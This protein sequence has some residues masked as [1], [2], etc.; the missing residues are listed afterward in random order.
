MYTNDKKQSRRIEGH[1][2][3]DL[4]TIKESYCKQNAGYT[5]PWHSGITLSD[6]ILLQNDI[7]LSEEAVLAIVD[8]AREKGWIGV[9]FPIYLNG[10]RVR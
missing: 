1:S 7:N 3:I 10:K 6:L 4:E 5:S 2:D 8:E 9:D